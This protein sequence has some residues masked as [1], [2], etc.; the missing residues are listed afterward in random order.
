MRLA[1]KLNT[2]HRF[3]NEM[4]LPVLVNKLLLGFAN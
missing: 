4:R 3:K 1:L 2:I